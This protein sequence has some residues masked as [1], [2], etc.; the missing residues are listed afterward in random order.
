[1]LDKYKFSKNGTIKVNG[2][3]IRVPEKYSKLKSRLYGSRH[4][5]RNLFLQDNLIPEI[6]DVCDYLYL[7]DI[8][9]DNINSI[10][11][12]DF[13]DFVYDFHIPFNHTFIANGLISHNTTAAEY[14]EQKYNI[15]MIQ[16]YTDRPPRYDGETGHTF[17]TSEEMRQ[18]PL[19]KKLAFTTFG[20]YNYCCTTD[21][22]VDRNTYVLDERGLD[23]LTKHFSHIYNIRSVFIDTD[24]LIRLNRGM[25]IYRNKEEVTK[26]LDRDEGMYNHIDSGEL[27]YYIILLIIMV[28]KNNYIRD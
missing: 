2:K 1:M 22:V 20:G 25:E 9:L 17:I 3:T 27:G 15:P 24:K 14:I 7:N 11:K 6:D 12:I 16:S 18:I 5:L 28:V 10:E 4:Y 19:E 13:N 8:Y 23:Y 21:N 26:R